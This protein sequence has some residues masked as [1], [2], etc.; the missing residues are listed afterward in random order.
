VVTVHDVTPLV[1]P[2]AYPP[3]VRGQIKNFFQRQQLKKVD[4]IITDSEAS[5]KD[6]IKYLKIDSAKIHPVY[7]A[8][9]EQFKRISNLGQVKEKFN[10]PEKFLLFVGSPNWNKNL[11]NLTQ[12][13]VD[14]GV[15]IVFAGKAFEKE[16]KLEHIE[17]RPFAQFLEKFED[18]PL[19]HILGFVSDEDIV[20]LYNSASALMLPS[21]YEGFGLTILEAQACGVPVITSDVSSMP[22]VA[23]DSALMVDPEKVLE[24]K[25]AIEKVLGDEKL[26]KELV[27]KG[28]ENVKRFSWKKTAE[29]TDKVYQQIL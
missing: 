21:F 10:L 12:A 16:R 18:N 24:I 14:A 2:K 8:P 26:R 28:E 11:V 13:A 22:E 17:L 27:K 3:G 15:D 25:A 5:K 9:G 7:L 29:E 19:V 20:P 23:G 1:F 4:A 6:I